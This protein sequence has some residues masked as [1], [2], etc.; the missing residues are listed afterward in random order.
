MRL[1]R[2]HRRPDIKPPRRQARPAPSH[3][4]PSATVSS[5]DRVTAPLPT[6]ADRPYH[7]NGSVR[8]CDRCHRQPG[9]YRF[10]AASRCAQKAM[11]E[12]GLCNGCMEALRSVITNYEN[13]L[14][15]KAAAM[16]NGQSGAPA[17]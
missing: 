11:P 5:I 15:Q 3:G 2:D 10:M 4:G 6:A 8:P 7:R 9:D 1:F 13:K 17:S 12:L 14:R 16:A